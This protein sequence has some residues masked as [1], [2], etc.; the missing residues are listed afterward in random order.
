MSGPLTSTWSASLPPLSERLKM[1]TSVIATCGGTDM[2][3]TAP[4]V[5][6][7]MPCTPPKNSTPLSAADEEPTVKPSVK[8]S[9]ALKWLTWPVAGSRRY[10]PAMVEHQSLPSRSWRIA[11]ILGTCIGVA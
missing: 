11:R 1:V 9:E 3:R 4:G 8:P 5:T 7:V 2:L 6:A 10:R